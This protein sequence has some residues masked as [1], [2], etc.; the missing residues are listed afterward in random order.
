MSKVTLLDEPAETPA[1]NAMQIKFLDD[2][3]RE[4]VGRLYMQSIDKMKYGYY[5]YGPNDDGRTLFNSNIMLSS[6]WGDDFEA[7]ADNIDIVLKQAYYIKTMENKRAHCKFVLNIELKPTMGDDYPA[8]LR[9]IKRYRNARMRD[10]EEFRFTDGDNSER[11]FML[12]VGNYNGKGATW[13]N[14]VSLFSNS[15]IYVVLESQIE[16]IQIP[17]VRDIFSDV[18]SYIPPKLASN[19]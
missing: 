11:L 3:Y 17:K 9:Q 16:R 14:V 12:I 10:L 4:K 5:Y 7:E 1:H 13:E 19:P 2:A 8:V 15:N 18:E 6:G